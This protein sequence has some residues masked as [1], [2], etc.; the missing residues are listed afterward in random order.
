MRFY[1]LPIKIFRRLVS[2][3]E[4]VDYD[5]SDDELVEYEQDGMMG[6]TSELVYDKEFPLLQ[7]DDGTSEHCL[8]ELTDDAFEQMKRSSTIF[9]VDNAFSSRPFR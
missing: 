5:S 1:S 9:S 4:C 6:N 3:V 2:G 7:D 8:T